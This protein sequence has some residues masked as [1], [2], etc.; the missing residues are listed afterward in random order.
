[1]GLWV[2]LGVAPIT[3]GGAPGQRTLAGETSALTHECEIRCHKMSM[4]AG[5]SCCIEEIYFKI[6]VIS[7]T[8]AIGQFKKSA[9]DAA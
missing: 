7:Y 5:Q 8:A 3:D 2:R 1:M 4:T 6:L 9:P